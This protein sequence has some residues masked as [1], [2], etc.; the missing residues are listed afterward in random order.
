MMV[1]RHGSSASSE[2][3]QGSISGRVRTVS[4]WA[5]TLLALGLLA[6]LG[7]A[8]RSTSPPVPELPLAVDPQPVAVREPVVA[9]PSAPE[10]SF[11]VPERI[12]IPSIGVDAPVVRVGVTPEGAM[13]SPEGREDTGWY[14]RGARPGDVGSAVIAGHSGYRTGRAVFDDLEQLKPGDVIYIVDETGTRIEFRVRESRLYAPGDAPREVF[15]SDGGRHLNLIT[16]T[17]AWD[18]SAGT[19]SQRLV[20]FSDAVIP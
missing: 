13:E 19:H 14:E 6:L 11:G 3:A 7:L 9:P 4:R 17:G 15:V 18:S 10:V 16:C 5:T 2:G 1:E 20:V 8:A 12:M